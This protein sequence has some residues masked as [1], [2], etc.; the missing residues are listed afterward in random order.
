LIIQAVIR[1]NKTG[2][3]VLIKMGENIDLNFL[4]EKLNPKKP[5]AKFVQP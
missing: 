1:S 5:L 3:R 2:A 4:T